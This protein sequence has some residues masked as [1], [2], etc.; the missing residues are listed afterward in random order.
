MS[1]YDPEGTGHHPTAS[2]PKDD[3]EIL[4][5]HDATDWFLGTSSLV[6]RGDTLYAVGNG[7]LALDSDSGER[8]FGHT[9]PY[10]STPAFAPASVYESDTLAV[11]ASSGVFGLNADGGFT[12][13]LLDRNVGTERWTGPQTAGGGFFG[14]AKADTPVTAT[15]RIYTALPG[16]N[17]IAAL[18]P[19]DGQVLWRRTHHKDDAVSADINRPAVRDGLVFTT[20]WPGQAAAYQAET[21]DRVWMVEL[22]D[23]L[24]LPPVA[25]EQGVVVPSREF[26]Y[27]LDQTDGSVVWQYS[28][29]G[30]ATE[31]TPAVANGTIFVANERDSLHAIDIETGQQRWT[32][33]F[34]GPS[35]PIVADGTV[36]AVEAGYSLVA[37]DAASG[38]MLFEYRPSEVPLST[39]IVGDGVLYAANRRRVVALREA[40]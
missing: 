38:D 18:D 7:L 21:G 24:L 3:V 30:N 8:K 1:R 20:N 11:T 32:V 14:P 9:G 40:N 39:P 23:Q 13:P 33:P 29:D 19:N 35:A 17:S 34:E 26:V 6:R 16:T 5:K 12:I 2:G 22:D 25:T 4:W 15:G 28:T 36:Y 37:I 27:L 10:Q 31:S